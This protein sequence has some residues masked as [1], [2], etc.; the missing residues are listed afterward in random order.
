MVASLAIGEEASA[1]EIAR[2]RSTFTQLD[3]DLDNRLSLEEFLKHSGQPAVLRRDFMLFD[4][5]RDGLLTKTEFA[6]VFVVPPANTRGAIPDPFDTL[7]SQAMDAIDE[8]YDHWNQRPGESVDS[9]RFVTNFMQSISTDG[10]YSIS[11]RIIQQADPN[12]DERVSRDEALQFLKQQLGVCWIDP[13]P[14]REPSGRVVNFAR[15]LETD[16]DRDGSISR[17]EFQ[18]RWWNETSLDEDFLR[19]DRDADGVISFAEYAH[20]QGPN[21]DDPVAWFR[22]ADTNLDALIDRIEMESATIGRRRNLVASSC[23]AF[24]D[25]GDGKL[26]LQEYRLSMHANVN[27]TWQSLPTDQNGD[28]RISFE[29]FEFNKA[30]LFDLQRRFYFHR[31]DADHDGSLTTNEFSFR[32][33]GES[34][35][36]MISI[37]GTKTRQLLRSDSGRIESPDVSPDGKQ[38]LFNRIPSADMDD[39]RIQ[40]LD[41]DRGEILQLCDGMQPSWSADGSEFVCARFVDGKGIWIMKGDGTEGRRIASG[42]APQWSPDGKTIAYLEGNGLWAY[43]VE[44]GHSRQ[45]IGPDDHPYQYFWWNT[46]WS[47]DSQRMILCGVLPGRSEAVLVNMQGPPNI[48]VRLSETVEMGTEFVWAPDGQRIIFPM[49]NRRQQRTQWFEI[50]PDGND[51]SSVVAELESEFSPKTGC[52]TPDGRWYISVFQH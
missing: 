5:D 37:D 18:S 11:G 36:V 48:R 22:D 50:D 15:F 34:S 7:V 35:L 10:N 25:D 42:W 39:S 43:D 33:Q 14:L 28:G 46:C 13:P 3:V 17:S 49:R 1:I 47:P 40:S 31:L 24:D 45:V 27:Y 19:N 12:Y 16:E 38:I 6:A 9:R 23:S 41:L 52:F 30:A 44:S 8:S 4:F 51:P 32:R 21:F 29:E 20:H 2:T 26:S